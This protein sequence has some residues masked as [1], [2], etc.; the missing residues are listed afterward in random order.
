MPEKAVLQ[1]L[2][3]FVIVIK[4]ILVKVYL[5][6]SIITL[7]QCYYYGITVLQNSRA[8]VDLQYCI[9]Y[10]VTLSCMLYCT[11]LYCIVLYCTSIVYRAAV[12]TG[13]AYLIV[14]FKEKSERA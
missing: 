3:C 6:S 2:Y 7:G 13:H 14:L 11:V 4:I 12:L 9:K 8:T 5:V 10:P 1:L